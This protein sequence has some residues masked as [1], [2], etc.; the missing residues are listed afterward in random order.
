MT[1][2]ERPSK[3]LHPG[4]DLTALPQRQ[5][6]VAEA[7]IQ[8]TKVQTYQGVAKQLELRHRAAL[9]R[10]AAHTRRY[11]KRRSEKSLLERLEALLRYVR[12]G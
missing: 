5:R 6:R 8:G 12:Q 10:N 11:F 1:P 9:A 3:T 4:L 2:L 7:L